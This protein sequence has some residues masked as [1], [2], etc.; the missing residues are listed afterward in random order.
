M[1]TDEIILNTVTRTRKQEM[2]TSGEGGFQAVR[3]S[4]KSLRQEC[5]WLAGGTS[6]KA[7]VASTDS[8]AGRG[9]AHTFGKSAGVGRGRIDEMRT[10]KI[11]LSLGQTFIK[12]LF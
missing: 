9:A 3:L 2:R 1:L 5:A 6:K 8:V 11:F 12:M 4:G 10:Y 7:S